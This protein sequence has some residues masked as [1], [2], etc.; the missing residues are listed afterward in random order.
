[1][2]TY[3]FLMPGVHVDALKKAASAMD[4][5]VISATPEGENYLIEL[6]ADNPFDLISIG[7][8]MATDSAMNLFN[9]TFNP[10]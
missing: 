7:R 9:E 5:D 3:R 1:M 6:M 8:V 2:E 10:R 4:V